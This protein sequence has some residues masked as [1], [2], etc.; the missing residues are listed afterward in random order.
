MKLHIGCGPVYMPGFFNVDLRDDFRTDF[1]GSI[2]DLDIEEN[3][4]EVI[5]SCHF[6]EHLDY[7]TDVVRCLELFHRWLTPDGLFRI[8]VPDMETVINYYVNGD[9]K[10]FGLPGSDDQSRWHKKDSRAERVMFF[11]R[12]WGHTIIFDFELINMLLQDAGFKNITKRKF[13]ESKIGTWFYDRFEIESLYVE[14]DK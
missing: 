9:K 5:W 7:P 12:H 13:R 1:C 6:L 8:A 14:A 2:F 3:S 10:L 11:M 4:A